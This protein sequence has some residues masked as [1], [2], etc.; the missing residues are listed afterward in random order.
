VVHV[1]S[2][3]LAFK[4][5][6]M[7]AFTVGN[8]LLVNGMQGR[9]DLNDQQVLL[10]EWCSGRWTCIVV[11]T[12]ERVS[13]HEKNLSLDAASAKAASELVDRR[14]ILCAALR[15]QRK[16]SR[17]NAGSPL[18]YLLWTHIPCA[19]SPPLYGV[20]RTSSKEKF[21]SQF[22]GVQHWV[23]METFSELFV[24]EF[25][26]KAAVFV[27]SLLGIPRLSRFRLRR[28]TPEEE[29][30]WEEDVYIDFASSQARARLVQSLRTA[31]RGVDIGAEQAALL[32]ASSP[33]VRKCMPP[34][35]AVA[36]YLWFAE[37]QPTLYHLLYLNGNVDGVSL[38]IER[39]ADLFAPRLSARD[40]VLG[41]VPS[42][43]ELV[44][45]CGPQWRWGSDGA[46]PNPFSTEEYS[47]VQAPHRVIPTSAPA[48]PPRSCISF[49]RAASRSW[50]PETHHRFPCCVR[51]RALPLLLLGYRLRRARDGKREW[52]WIELWISQVMPLCVTA[53]ACDH[54]K[55]IDVADSV[56]SA[57]EVEA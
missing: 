32:F 52:A 40:V 4:L 18:A 33:G 21:P 11:K 38:L 31:H 13:L 5:Y 45:A 22:P 25:S 3:L 14:Q 35:M 41:A 29:R 43:L 37:E 9:K 10:V 27:N 34:P 53:C 28:F 50:S 46:D 15:C 6:A 19:I 48:L 17:Y 8:V 16:L 56:Y 20:R 39:G 49:Q 44:H 12:T 36:F 23:V 55:L 2:L 26:Y 57:A 47:T 51:T 54:V 42:P 7:S 30:V 1:Q 24:S